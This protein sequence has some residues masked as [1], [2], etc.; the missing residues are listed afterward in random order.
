MYLW[1]NGEIYDGEWSFGVKG[2]YGIW[3][4]TKGDSYIGLWKRG[5]AHGIGV[6]VWKNGRQKI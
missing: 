3:K 6:H 4:G 5:K 1:E 2:G